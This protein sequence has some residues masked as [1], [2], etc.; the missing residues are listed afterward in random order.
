V[1]LDAVTAISPGTKDGQL[2]AL[3]GTD[4]VNTVTVPD[5]AGTLLN[6]SATLLATSALTLVWVEALSLW[7]ELS[8]NF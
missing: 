7:R 6:G 2:L 4:D 5:G 8:R 1:T 3:L